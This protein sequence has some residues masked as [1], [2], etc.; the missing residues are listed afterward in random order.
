MELKTENIKDE[1]L[2][3]IPVD[4][5]I[6]GINVIQVLLNNKDLYYEKLVISK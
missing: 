1:L 5:L 6:E 4:N 3:E 2:K